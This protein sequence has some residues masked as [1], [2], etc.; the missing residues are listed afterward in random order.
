MRFDRYLTERAGDAPSQGNAKHS[1][2]EN[3]RSDIVETA[4]SLHVIAQRLNRSKEL[5]FENAH[6]FMAPL[7]A[8]VGQISEA[9]HRLGYLPQPWS[10]PDTEILI[11]NVIQESLR[12]NSHIQPSDG[13][14]AIPSWT[15]VLTNEYNLSNIIIDKG[16]AAHANVE[17]FPSVLSLP[18]IEKDNTLL[19][20]N[21]FHEVGHWISTHR[22][23]GE[24][25]LP[26]IE[27]YFTKTSPPNL[28]AKDWLEEIIADLIAVDLV[29]P[30][31][32]YAFATFALYTCRPPLMRPS[33]RYPSPNARFKYLFSRLSRNGGIE[34]TREGGL[35]ELNQL[36]GLRLELENGNQSIQGNTIEKYYTELKLAPEEIADFDLQVDKAAEKVLRST[37]YQEIFNG[38]RFA[39]PDIVVC[40]ALTE[41][42]YDGVLIAT[43][44]NPLKD[45]WTVDQVQQEYLSARQLLKE[46]VNRVAHI[47]AAS[48]P[49]RW[50]WCGPERRAPVPHLIFSD[51]LFAAF[52]EQT[53]S[54]NLLWEL[55]RPINNLDE[56]VSN[57]IEAVSIARFY[58]DGEAHNGQGRT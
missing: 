15:I 46:D 41:K 24:S 51:R 49:I 48:A 36:W 39:E 12:L 47:M 28:V 8:I 21:L 20:A 37:S 3:L 19:W 32:L 23:I 53:F 42:L 9:H 14:I 30:A 50:A 34:A 44:S 29:G 43:R 5:R 25:I 35:S 40:R 45:R 26:T 27:S 7:Q 11:G 57:S 54:Q 16:D 4:R 38:G 1:V 31:Y 6:T 10:E 17:P 55:W 2:I 52:A 56:M 13:Q 18:A 22:K 33:Q 58:G